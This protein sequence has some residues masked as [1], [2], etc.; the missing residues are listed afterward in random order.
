MVG[1]FKR[2]FLL[3]S[4]SLLLQCAPVLLLSVLAEEPQQSEVAAVT[5]R[6]QEMIDRLQ[7]TS[8]PVVILDYVH[9]P[10]A[11]AAYPAE[12]KQV[13][14]IKTPEELKEYTR[15]ILSDPQKFMNERFEQIAARAPPEV[16]KQMRESSKQVMAAM[17]EIKRRISARIKD[18]Q[19]SIERVDI[20]SD[21]RAK[22]VLRIVLDQERKRSPVIFEK[23][24]GVWYLP[25]IDFAQA[26]GGSIV[27]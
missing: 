3:F 20:I 9:W 22:V 16:A 15:A 7:K 19:Y 4:A 10:S 8:D 23:H 1:I 18:T 2:S 12:E 26:E 17:G 5:K 11:F 13:S 21:G 25:S 6:A 24:D 14:D 27:Q